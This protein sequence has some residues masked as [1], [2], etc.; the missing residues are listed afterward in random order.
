MPARF[1]T[2]DTTTT[3]LSRQNLDHNNLMW[4]SVAPGSHPAHKPV[5][6][7][8]RWELLDRHPWEMPSLL[9]HRGSGKHSYIFLQ[10]P[11]NWQIALSPKSIYKLR[12]PAV[13]SN[14]FY[15]APSL[16]DLDV[17]NSPSTSNH[18]DPQGK[19]LRAVLMGL[20][21]TARLMW[22]EQLTPW[23]EVSSVPSE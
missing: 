20:V 14:C 4:T 22:W 12:S 11:S 6:V 8:I 1:Y 5:S 13:P 15:D 2:A 17:R 18:C 19:E 21:M 9:D 3:N 7:H 16:P 23:L 10:Q